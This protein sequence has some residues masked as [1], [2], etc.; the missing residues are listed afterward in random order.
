MTRAFEAH[1]DMLAA[2]AKRTLSLES[3]FA[4]NLS[5]CLQNAFSMIEP[6]ASSIKL[7]EEVLAAGHS[8]L[9]AHQA[10]VFSVAR[11]AEEN[12]RK[13]FLGAIEELR[14]EMSRCPSSA[15]CRALGIS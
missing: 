14:T 2:E 7:R 13:A 3:T 8:L 1:L 6:S 15:L 5:A 10:D 12:A 9:R 4:N 11:T